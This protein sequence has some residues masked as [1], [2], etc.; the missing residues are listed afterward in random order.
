MNLHDE[1]YPWS[2]KTPESY[3]AAWIHV[4]NIF[5]SKNLA[6]DALQWVWCVNNYDVPFDGYK[7]EEYY[8]GD[9]Y[10]D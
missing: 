9:V 3:T 4:H 6:S 2:N 1:A 8:P 5:K 10:V 7:A